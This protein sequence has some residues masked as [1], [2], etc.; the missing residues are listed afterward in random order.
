MKAAF[1]K[2]GCRDSCYFIGGFVDVEKVAVE[3][4]GENDIRSV[5][6]KS[7]EC[8]SARL[9]ASLTLL[10]F[11]VVILIEMRLVCFQPKLSLKFFS[12]KKRIIHSSF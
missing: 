4:D 7:E 12:C 6:Q 2:P 3:V 11:M 1:L 10:L 5:I 8:F 9:E